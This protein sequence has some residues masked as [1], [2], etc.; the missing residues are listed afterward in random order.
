V[1]ARL[2]YGEAA[3]D[4]DAPVVVDHGASGNKAQMY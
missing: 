3:D 4:V 2:V 1:S